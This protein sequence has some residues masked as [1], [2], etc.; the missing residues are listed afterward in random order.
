MLYI[1][2]KIV[3]FTTQLKYFIIYYYIVCSLEIFLIHILIIYIIIWAYDKFLS[4][5]IIKVLSNNNGQKFVLINT[6]INALTYAIR[7]R[8]IDLFIDCAGIDIH[9]LFPTVL[10]LINNY[11]SFKILH[12]C[13]NSNVWKK[14][15][16]KSNIS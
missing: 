12:A 14:I 1:D 5:F 2:I 3:N 8:L 7:K 11:S 9:N 15:K 16:D 10:C 4:L 13:D 6:R